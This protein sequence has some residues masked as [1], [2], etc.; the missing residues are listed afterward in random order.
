MP[1]LFK[2]APELNEKDIKRIKSKV[3]VQGEDDC[4][5]FN[6][7]LTLYKIRK[8]GTKYAVGR[9]KI[10]YIMYHAHKLYNYIMTDK[11]SRTLDLAHSDKCELANNHHCCNPTHLKFQTRQ[12]N[13]LQ[14]VRLKLLRN[15]EK[16]L[17]LDLMNKMIGENQLPKVITEATGFS[18]STISNY[19]KKFKQA[20][21]AIAS[22]MVDD[23]CSDEEIK[24]V[25]GI[26]LSDV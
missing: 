18:K 14:A 6:R 20:K 22:E 4:W 25:T 24:D 23:D 10:N 7:N 17:L 3:T 13:V 21:L 26:T 1:N 16:Q 15:P 12:E 2:P 8:D 5:L 9:I 19:K 11:W